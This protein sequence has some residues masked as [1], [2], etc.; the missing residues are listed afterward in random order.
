[1]SILN[2]GLR[3]SGLAWINWSIETLVLAGFY[4]QGGAIFCLSF[5]CFY[6]IGA[7]EG[8]LKRLLMLFKYK[9]KK[10]DEVIDNK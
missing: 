4:S 6:G 9:K 3:S 8:I 5:Y 1:M 7:I 10:T 2:V